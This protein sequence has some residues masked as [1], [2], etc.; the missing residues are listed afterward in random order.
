MPTMTV[1]ELKR[2]HDPNIVDSNKL[3][4]LMPRT[5]VIIGDKEDLV[6][7]HWQDEVNL[8]FP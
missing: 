7:I 5:G 3:D 2:K 4:K 8:D 6:D 1:D